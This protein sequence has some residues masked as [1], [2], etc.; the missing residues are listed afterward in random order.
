MH[1][2][3]L[4]EIKIFGIFPQDP[5]EF[6]IFR[7]RVFTGPRILMVV[8]I[9]FLCHWSKAGKHLEKFGEIYSRW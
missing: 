8:F 7:A 5:S 6:H 3:V 4:E 2:I 9:L 1:N